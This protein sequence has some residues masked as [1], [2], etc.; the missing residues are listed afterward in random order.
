[1]PAA[2][3]IAVSHLTE[4]PQYGKIKG[5]TFGTVSDED[6]RATRQSWDWRDKDRRVA[7]EQP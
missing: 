2:T 3:T 4:A 1:L 7:M 6:R 5:L